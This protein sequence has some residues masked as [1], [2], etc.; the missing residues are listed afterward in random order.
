MEGNFRHVGLDITQTKEGVIAEQN[1]HINNIQPI[2]I[3]LKLKS[4]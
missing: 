2:P 1:N 4:N 3:S